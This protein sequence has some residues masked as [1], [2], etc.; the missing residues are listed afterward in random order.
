MNKYRQ[1]LFWG[2]LPGNN[3]LPWDNLGFLERPLQR[4]EFLFDKPFMVYTGTNRIT[5]LENFVLDTKKI[6]RLKGITRITQNSIKTY[7]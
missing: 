6:N 1:D 7:P 5:Q 4:C 2:N 3:K